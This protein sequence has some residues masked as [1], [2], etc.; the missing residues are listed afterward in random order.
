[1]AA[2]YEPPCGA[3]IVSEVVFVKASE[4]LGISAIRESESLL[5]HA[6]VSLGSIGPRA[7][8]VG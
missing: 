4:Q 6:V 3:E 5:S 8:Q 2:P 1:M 7:V